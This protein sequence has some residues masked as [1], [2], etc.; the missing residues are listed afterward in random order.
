MTRRARRRPRDRAPVP[1]RAGGVRAHHRPPRLRA[2]AAR[3]APTSRSCR[4]RG[5]P[6]HTVGKV[7]Q[8]FDERRDRPRPPGRDQRRRRSPRPRTL[9][10]ELDER[11]RVHQPRRDR[12]GL[13]PPRRRAGLPRRAA[14]DRRGGRRAGSSGS[15]P[16]ATCWSSPPTT[17][18][19]RPRRAPTTRAST[20]RCS[21]ASP[22]TAAAATTGRSPT[23]APPRC[24]GWPGRDAPALPGEPFVP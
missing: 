7:K 5:V 10:D 13:R 23:S 2:A 24:A 21:R 8:V 14:G 16:S 20:R 1:G 15:T 19:T 22:A 3:A 11:P 18:A 12:P 9:I 4:P 6:V 17:A